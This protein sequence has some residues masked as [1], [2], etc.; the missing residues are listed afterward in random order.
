M[1]KLLYRLGKWCYHYKWV[2]IALWALVL[3]TVGTLAGTVQKGF[4]DSVSI[5]GTES[6]AAVE[7]L[8]EQ[9]PDARN[10]LYSTGVTFV[11]KAP[12]GHT[13]DEYTEQIDAVIDYLNAHVTR[14]TDTERYGNPVTYND[15]FLEMVI[16]QETALGIPEAMAEADAA[17][18][19]MLSEDG[20]IGF[21]T[22]NIDVPTASELTEEDRQQFYDAMGAVGDTDMQVEIMGQ[23]T[24]DPIEIEGR[25]EIIGLVVAF[26]VLLLTF[27]SVVAAGLPLL[28]A[29][30]GVGLGS[31]AILIGTHFVDLNNITPVLSVMIGLAVGIDYALFIISRYKAEY[32]HDSREEAA[33]LAVGTAGSAVVFAGLTVV[34]ALAAL[35]TAGIPFLTYM[36]A[37]A[38]FT[39]A[40]SVVVALTLV[41]AL[42]GVFGRYAFGINIFRW[43]RP[44]PGLSTLSERWVRL[45]HRHPG[46]VFAAVVFVLGA[47]TLPIV[48][49]E[50]A[51]PSDKTSSES[52]TQRRAAD[53]LEEGFG[54]GINAP[55]LLVLDAH[56]V[57][58][59]SPALQPYIDAQVTEEST[60]EERTKAA[61]TASF[62]Y[63]VQ[64]LNAVSD[65]KHA[66]LLSVN[67]DSTA[68]QI[69]L[70]PTSGPQEAVTAQIL[71]GLRVLEGQ[72]E[73]STGISIG[74]TGLTPIQQDVTAKLENAMPIYLAIIVGLA[75]VLLL[76]VFRS[77]MVPIV[78]GLGFL[79]SVGA[80][81]GTTV[82]FWQKGL[83]GFVDAP[84]PLISFMP[85]FLIG[86]TFGLAMDYQ[87]F[88]VSRMRER[89]VSYTQ[90]APGKRIPVGKNEYNLVEKSIIEGF[91][92]GSRVVAGAAIIMISVFAAFIDQS[93]AFI[94]IFGFALGAGVLFDAFFIR[95]SLVPATLF[96]LG[97]STW[98]I[99]KWLDKLLPH[100]D[101]EGEGLVAMVKQERKD[102]DMAEEQAL[103]RLRANH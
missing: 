42:L 74:I 29:I 31:F 35:A 99:P 57:N 41:P 89:Y 37:A 15:E 32:T 20:R 60:A 84:G 98:W 66:Q 5:P 47:L 39:V 76:L 43:R 19:S 12:E 63:T 65:V 33:G 90:H 59:D 85:I 13:L 1:A 58:E 40:I 61:Q 100:V 103:A 101:V 22:F 26:I 48:E 30:L 55:F 50:L 75:I 73:D 24:D 79:L 87:V 38:A 72:I 45:V 17:N 51:L 18:L 68:A 2:V 52:M 44:K 82:L 81:F 67:S 8:M 83:W 56:N 7:T 54:A 49:L 23:S 28:T 77:I 96:L 25:S 88:L 71:E 10:P 3:L 16:E 9:F 36:G 94:Q 11:F 97:R 64:V 102:R 95:M 91:A 34:I 86:V 93:I 27:G 69:Y 21:F 46:S 62:L 80:A 78:A 53:I 4:S 92:L 70:T 14:I 6:Q